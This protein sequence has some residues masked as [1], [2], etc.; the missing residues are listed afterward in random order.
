[1]RDFFE[2]RSKVVATWQTFHVFYDAAEG[3]SGARVGMFSDSVQLA[4]SL[5]L[6]SYKSDAFL[7]S[8]RLY[9]SKETA[10]YLNVS[11]I[12]HLLP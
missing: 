6:V 9:F 12:K 10:F 5:P 7:W 3:T 1:M 4:Q 11:E 2:D 8:S